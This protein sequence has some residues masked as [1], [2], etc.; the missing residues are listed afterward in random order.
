MKA[1]MT[2][3]IGSVSLSTTDQWRYANDEDRNHENWT[4]LFRHQR[5]GGLRGHH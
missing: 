5:R 3:Q 1:A 4:S 2:K